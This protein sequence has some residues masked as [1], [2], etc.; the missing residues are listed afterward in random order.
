M[1]A[2]GGPEAAELAARVG[3]GLVCT[4]PDPELVEAYASAGGRGDKFAQVT[5]CWAESED[6]ARRTAFECW[7]NAAL[8]GPLAQELALPSHFEQAA[9]MVTEDDVAELVACGPD[10]ARHLEAIAKYADAGFDH[11]Y[12]HQVGPDQEGFF[13]FYERELQPLISNLESPSGRKRAA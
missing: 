2:A 11:V 10:P 12:V 6:A 13:A 8:K 5:V 4:A 7:P 1:V 3:D 9:A